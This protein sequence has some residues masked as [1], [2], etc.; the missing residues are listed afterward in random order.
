MYQEFGEVLEHVS[1]KKYNTY[2]IGGKAK[3]IV[4]PSSIE[5][6][7][8]LISKLRTDNTKFYV[9]GNGSNIILPDEDFDGVIIILKKIKDILIEKDTV[10]ISAGIMMPYLNNYLLKKGY[11]NFVWACGLPGTLGGSIIGNAGCFK[12]EAQDN[13]L[14]I[15]VID[16]SNKIV[17]IKKEEINFSYRKSDIKGI[18]I[19]ATYKLVKNNEDVEKSIEILNKKRMD[20]QPFD[21]KTAGSVFR[22]PEGFAAGKLI[23]DAGLK[24]HQIGGAVV[25][26]KHANFIYNNGTATS[27]DILDLIEYI[28]KVIKEKYNIDLTLEQK[29][30]KWDW[31]EKTK[32]SKKEN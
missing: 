21:K 30:V 10:K 14:S 25:S 28:K 20:T 31:Y 3:Y 32:G 18:I 7:H 6:L 4:F 12:N 11:G 1:L 22:N 8:K 23:E 2:G 5:N 24:K 9:I 16:D 17:S 19:S 15:E 26:E 13:L 29:V 27:K